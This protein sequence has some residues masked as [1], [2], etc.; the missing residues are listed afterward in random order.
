MPADSQDLHPT[1]R[2]PDLAAPPARSPLLQPPAHLAAPSARDG[3][4]RLPRRPLA[5][6]VASPA[7]GRLATMLVLARSFHLHPHDLPTSPTSPRPPLAS[8][9]LPRD[10]PPQATSPP[11]RLP[12]P[13]PPPIPLVRQL[14]VVT[15]TILPADLDETVF[16]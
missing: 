9:L 4:G 16:R 3:R 14:P 2:L 7:V 10:S 13:R 8:P 1:T 12:Q 15:M 5:A 11:A 6:L